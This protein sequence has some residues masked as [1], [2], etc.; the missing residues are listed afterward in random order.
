MT[1]NKRVDVKRVELWDFFVG[2]QN[3][4]GH[5][6]WEGDYIKFRVHTPS[7]A[8]TTGTTISHSIKHSDIKDIEDVFYDVSWASVP[9]PDYLLWILWIRE[10]IFDIRSPLKESDKNNFVQ[11]AFALSDQDIDGET[12]RDMFD[13]LLLEGYLE[14]SS[15]DCQVSG[16]A[17]SLTSKGK[18]VA[19]IMFTKT[20]KG[21]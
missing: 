10:E 18:R 15:V 12:E 4:K 3:I 17:Y 20:E 6:Q 11:R 2:I 9:S 16:R 8:E 1:E 21:T 19:N 13:I 5:F 14:E 7:D